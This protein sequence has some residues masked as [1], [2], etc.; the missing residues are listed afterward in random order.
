[1]Y[2][3]SHSTNKKVQQM[4]KKLHIQDHCLVS[5]SEGSTVTHKT[6]HKNCF[7]TNLRENLQ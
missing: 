2:E 5:S 6:H 3:E 1:M 4:I 7:I